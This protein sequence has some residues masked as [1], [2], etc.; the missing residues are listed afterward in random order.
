MVTKSVMLTKQ[1]LRIC[2]HISDINKKTGSPSV[3]SDHYINLNHNFR[4]EVKILDYSES[5]HNKRL[6]INSSFSLCTSTSSTPSSTSI[7]SYF[8]FL[9]LS[10]IIFSFL[11][12]MS[13]FYFIM[14]HN[15]EEIIYCFISFRIVSNFNRLSMPETLFIFWLKKFWFFTSKIFIRIN[16]FVTKL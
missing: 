6:I 12:W 15:I 7:P 5:S 14:S 4:N 8:H 1:K 3:I 10:N 13:I 11:L 9:L 16:L 2:E